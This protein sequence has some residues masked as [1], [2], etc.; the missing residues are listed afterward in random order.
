MS[1]ATARASR[2]NW[3]S[4]ST[5]AGWSACTCGRSGLTVAAPGSGD[6]TALAGGSIT[7]C[8]LW[9]WTLGRDGV[10]ATMVGAAAGAAASG[11]GCVVGRVRRWWCGASAACARG[12]RGWSSG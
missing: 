12:A 5:G 6:N 9:G 4:T 2:P 11:C 3:L 7:I 1:A 8:S 10:R